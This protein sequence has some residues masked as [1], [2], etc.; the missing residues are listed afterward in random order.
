MECDCSKLK[1]FAEIYFDLHFFKLIAF[2]A[3]Y[4]N[5]QAIYQKNLLHFTLCK[6]IVGFIYCK[7]N[8]MFDV[9]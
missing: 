1:Y 5:S 7:V 2:A 6:R 4:L 3:N 9:S 8:I